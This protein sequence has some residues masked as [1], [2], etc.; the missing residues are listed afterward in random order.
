MSI[1]LPKKNPVIIVQI[2]KYIDKLN[3]E[4]VN[5]L[6]NILRCLI[7]KIVAHKFAKNHTPKII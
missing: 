1:L 6:M 2:N 7:A 5:I 4:N 3:N